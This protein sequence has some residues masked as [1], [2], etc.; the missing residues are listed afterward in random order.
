MRVLVTGC[1]GYIG[2]VLTRQLLQRGHVVR[3]LDVLLFGGESLLP[4]AGHPDFEFT[5]ADLRDEQSVR[6]ALDGIEGVVHL[7][8]IVG[9]P[10]CAKD[11]DLAV[12]VN[13]GA[14]FGLYRLAGEQ[15]K[16]KRF[17]FAS[18][19]SNY[20][21][22]EGGYVTE[23][24]PLKPVSLYAELKVEFERHLLGSQ[25]RPDLVATALRFATVYGL[26][27]RMRFDL[28]VNEFTRDLVLGRR[29]QVFGE[30]FW[31]PYCHVEDL[32]RSVVDVLEADPGIVRRN[33]FNVGDTG[34]N[35]T[36]KMIVETIYAT[37]AG[38]NPGLVSYVRRT[39]DPR[40]YKVDFSR[41]RNGLGFRI[42]KRIPVGISEI[43]AAIRSGLI[44]DPDAAAYRNA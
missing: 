11:P 34:E 43:A 37:V 35:Y 4:V 8:A 42:S 19:C 28:T 41:I 18:T 23:Q 29:L 24:S 38:V 44:T 6:A 22:M 36:K 1:A 2:S 13:R 20:G 40:D 25:A 30:Q 15:R 12:A 27:T 14:A 26:S 32:A 5:R 21:K 31:R 3:G 7:A 10:A 17:V 9:D 39:E 16:M 33:V